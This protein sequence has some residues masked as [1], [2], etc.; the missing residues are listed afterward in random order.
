MT[1]QLIVE[2]QEYLFTEVEDFK[3]EMVT[4]VSKNGDK[5]L[6]VEGIAMQAETL[7]G[8][9]RVYPTAVMSEAVNQYIERYVSKNQALGECDHPPR[10]NV[11]LSEA[12]HLIEKLWVDGNNICARAKLLGTDKG[13]TVRALIEGGWTPTVSTRGLGKA[14]QINE[15]RSKFG[16]AYTEITKFQLTAGFDFVHNQSAPGAIMA[17]V[18]ESNGQIYIPLKQKSTTDWDRVSYGL[19]NL[20]GLNTPMII[21]STTGQD[22]MKLSTKG[23]VLIIECDTSKWSVPVKELKK[24][25]G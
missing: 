16:R 21:E 19:R 17:G 10:P 4:E 5:E 8:N 22:G 3:V 18:Y 14:V 13:R 23:G 1:D 12:S 7:N 15:S 9:G 20:A 6:Y 25:L 24:Y 2:S 11:L